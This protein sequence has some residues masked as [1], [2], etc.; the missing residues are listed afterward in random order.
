[1]T[2]NE[3]ANLVIEWQTPD[4]QMAPDCHYGH[5]PHTKDVE[6]HCDVELAWGNTWY[7]YSVRDDE[8]NDTYPIIRGYAQTT[9][10]AKSTCLLALQVYLRQLKENQP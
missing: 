6:Y 10:E 7:M 5:T 2:E 4:K 9:E 1:M 3:I 8:D